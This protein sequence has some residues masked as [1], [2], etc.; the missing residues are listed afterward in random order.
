MWEAR[1]V[2]GRWEYFQVLGVWSELRK[3]GSKIEGK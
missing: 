3:G 2:G 1:E